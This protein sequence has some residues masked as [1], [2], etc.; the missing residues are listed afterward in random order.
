MLK[1][2]DIQNSDNVAELL[3]DT[4]LAE[5]SQ[6]VIS[7]YDIDKDSR[8]EWEETIED[9][10]GIAKQVMEQKNH[11]WP[12]A[13]N[14]KFPLITKGSID[15]ASRMLPEIIKNDKV[16]K[17]STTGADP[18]GVIARRA[19]RV[20]DHMSF[21]LLKQT[22]D[23]EESTDRILHVLPVLGTV[24]KKTFYDE[25]EERPVSQM[26][27]PNK[28][29][30]NYN[31]ESLE[32]A[33]RVTHEF[34][35][36]SND[37][38]ERIRAG[39]Y[40]DCDVDQ[41]KAAEG[42][43][44][45]TYDPPIDLIEQHCWLDLDEDGYKEPYIV[46]VHKTSR[47]VLRIVERFNKVKKKKN[48]EIKRITPIQYFTDY[49]FLKSPDGGFYSVGFGTLLYPLN[50][51]INTLL[52]Q[53]IDSGTLHNQ[54][55]GFIGRGLRIK[56]GEIKAS[57][58]SYKVV[59][60]ASGSSLRDNIFPLPTK[61]PSKVLFEL[62]GLLIDIGRDLTS[63]NEALEGKA[64]AQ[65]VAATTMLT[66]VEQG[67]KVYNAITKRIFRSLKQELLKIYDL[68]RRF[69]T[70]EEYQRVLNDP[71]VSV[72]DDYEITSYDVLPV[73]DPNMAS[74]A[75]RNAKAQALM[76]IP[77]LDPYET[78]KYFL[79][80]LQLDQ[81]LIDKLLPKPNPN[82]PPPA[83]VLKAQAE[84]ERAKAQAQEAMAKASEVQAKIQLEERKL[85][86][87]EQFMQAQ[88]QEMMARIAKME[89]DAK[90]NA[91]KLQLAGL[92]KA[93]EIEMDMQEM[94]HKREKD[95]AD[96]AV[97]AAGEATKRYAV[98]KKAEV[99]K[100]K[101]KGGNTTNGANQ[102]K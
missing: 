35:V 4:Q 75:Q 83:E 9:A 84:A 5:I 20:Q 49:H 26:C 82:A 69:L 44:E 25:I 34:T 36:S 81:K 100:M 30:V 97:K 11:P 64:P 73:A 33:R 50:N 52:N 46:I 85:M 3:E 101:P 89:S 71:R 6:Q 38:V 23:W 72:K 19:K 67:M 94:A 98:D 91:A 63:T 39:L 24:F 70:D 42:F 60:A 90:Q 2:K 29:V 55:S 96:I 7:G 10:M 80:S 65:N 12:G 32:K 47:K 78:S 22:D 18:E 28:V 37:I 68:N 87:Q 62:L 8:A 59:D 99:D 61:E 16:V 17:V 14:V 21:Q 56:G 57:M 41:L 76:G 95:K 102:S 48:G 31:A 58:G 53:L 92:D 66:L 40:V 45:D 1:L 74:D 79:E 15:F 93:H 88:M 43:E 13:S 51:S 27:L 77:G 54:Q 86:G